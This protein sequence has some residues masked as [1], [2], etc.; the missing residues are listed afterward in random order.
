M[1]KSIVTGI[2]GSSINFEDL[3]SSTVVILD[4]FHR[5][6]NITRYNGGTKIPIS[7]AQHS[8]AIEK[9]LQQDGASDEV[10][11]LALLHDS[12]EAFMGDLVTPLKH[13]FPEY[14]KLEDALFDVIVK[15]LEVDITFTEEQWAEVK[16]HDKAIRLAEWIYLNDNKFHDHTGAWSAVYGENPT[17]DPKY[18]KALE[19]HINVAPD[20]TMGRLLGRFWCLVFRILGA[21]NGKEKWLS[22]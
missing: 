10:R 3:A 21:R 16:R 6:S 11:L 12:T 20:I 15:S 1:K 7:V 9:V 2:Y 17:P 4:I 5:L 22:S 8:L 14:V 19:S 18:I 13:H